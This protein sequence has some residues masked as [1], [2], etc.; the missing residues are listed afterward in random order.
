GVSDDGA[1]S[2]QETSDGGYIIA[3]RTKSFGTH[4]DFYVIK[5]D[6]K[7]DTLWTRTYGRQYDDAPYSIQEISDGGYII[8][9]SS[10][11]IHSGFYRNDVYLVKINSKGNPQWTR[12]FTEGPAAKDIWGQSVK[13]TPDGGYIIVGLDY[14][15][16]NGDYFLLKTDSL[17]NRQ[18]KYN[19]GTLSEER[20]YS[21][22]LTLDGGYIIVGHSD[23]IFKFDVW[24]VKTDSLGN[25]EWNRIWG[26]LGYDDRGFSVQQ[27]LDGGYVISGSYFVEGVLDVWLIKTDASG[28]TLWTRIFGG[29]RPDEGRAVQQTFDGGYIIAGTKQYGHPS[30]SWGDIYLIKTDALGVTLWTR[31]FGGTD[32]ERG[33]SGHQTSD[34]G[35]IVAGR[36]KSFGAGGYDI[37]V[38]KTDSLG[39]VDTFPPEVQILYPHGGESFEPGDTCDITWFAED[40]VGVDSISIYYSIDAGLNWDT[41]A[42]GEL[43]DS[44]YEWI[45]PSTPS[46]SCL[47]KILGYDPSLN[48]GEDQSDSLFSISSGVGI[49]ENICTPI[50]SLFFQC[51]PNPFSKTTVISFQCPVISEKEKITLSIYNLSGRLVKSFILTTDHSALSTAV[52]WDGTNDFGN[53]VQSGVY[54]CKF[55]A[56]DY[57]LT[58]KLLLLR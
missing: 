31:I 17:G 11:S 8:V 25:M 51:T 24:L 45:I 39:N 16:N 32:A 7:G 49:E 6:A 12:I 58:K 29:S 33:Y 28:D 41:I 1:Y 13:Q 22:Q 30:T 5:I 42:T 3:G 46:D 27:T 35:Y 10:V 20:A 50:S 9:G 18:W 44:L 55:V 56:G 26:N 14:F 43:N 48:I 52:S 4:F 21:V 15:S 57:H 34:S 38:I 37:Y 36:T 47:V 23:M 40:N 54:F 19:Y 53:P 2:I